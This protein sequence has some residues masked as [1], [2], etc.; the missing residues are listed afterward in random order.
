MAVPSIPAVFLLALLLQQ[1][2]CG[3]VSPDAIKGH[4]EDALR[5]M[6][7]NARSQADPQHQ[8]ILAFTCAQGVGPDFVAKLVPYLAG[9]RDTNQKLQWGGLAL[10]VGGAHYRYILLFFD[11][12]WVRYDLN[13]H[14]FD[15]FNMTPAVL[16]GYRQACG[17]PSP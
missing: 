2:E 17:F 13:T 5:P 6:F 7:P 12:G 9:D 15:A 4:V 1:R 11:G 8:A 14:G 16:Q 3:L 10:S